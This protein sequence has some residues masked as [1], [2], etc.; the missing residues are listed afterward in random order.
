MA[1]GE[2]IT[3]QDAD[4]G[5]CSNRIEFQY[6]I[7]QKYNSHHVNIDWQQYQDEFNGK[8]LNYQITPDDIVSTSEI[9]TILKNSRKGLFKKPFGKNE[10]KNPLE[11]IIRSF[12]RKYLRDWPSY[13]CAANT[14]L[15]K[16][17]VFTKCWFRPWYERTM[18]ASS[19]RG[20]DCDFNFWVAETFQNSIA[21]KIPLLLWRVTSNNPRYTDTKYKPQ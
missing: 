21:I 1:K 19:G 3:F 9:L 16:K 10:N 8:E 12:N 15:L 6:S 5:S 11:K 4:D 2:L 7:M 17:E 20:T 18:P 13:P 14:P